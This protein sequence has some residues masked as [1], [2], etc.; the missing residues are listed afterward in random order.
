MG[1]D[2]K[3]G[4]E[5]FEVL[6]L[7]A[8]VGLGDQQGKVGVLDARGLDPQVDLGLHT[9]PDG[10]SVRANHH[11]AADRAVVRQLRFGHDV[12]VPAWEVLGLGR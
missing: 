8:Q 6:G 10:V 3:L 9:L 11:R 12:L 4:T 1:D 5:P 7:A 2:R